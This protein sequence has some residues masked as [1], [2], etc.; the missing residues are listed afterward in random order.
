[1]YLNDTYVSKGASIIHGRGAT[2]DQIAMF[3]EH[4]NPLQRLDM[5]KM[6]NLELLDIC[7]DGAYMGM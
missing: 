5:E 2:A 4:C 7:Q 3:S 1:M 6:Y